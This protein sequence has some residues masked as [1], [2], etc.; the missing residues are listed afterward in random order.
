MCSCR[1]NRSCNIFMMI[2]RSKSTNQYG[3]SL[4]N[5]W[6][7]DLPYF[8]KISSIAILSTSS[9][10]LMTLATDLVFLLV[11]KSRTIHMVIVFLSSIA[12]L[13]NS[14]EERFLKFFKTD[15][16]YFLS[17]V[18]YLHPQGGGDVEIRLRC[19]YEAGTNTA[20]RIT[21]AV[22][23]GIPTDVEIA[24]LRRRRYIFQPVPR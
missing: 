17:S 4:W 21:S 9:I 19:D 18:F 13:Q 1:L 6:F 8:A 5:S 11:P 16:H 7:G 22:A 14:M 23:D 12:F 20:V 2:F 10:S 15:I 24:E 3:Y